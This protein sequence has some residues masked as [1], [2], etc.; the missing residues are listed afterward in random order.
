ME[1]AKYPAYAP[2]AVRNAR[3]ASISVHGANLFNLLPRDIRD[4]DTGTVDMFKARLD[5]WL[6]TVPDQPT[7][8]G[9]QRA[10]ATNSLIDQTVCG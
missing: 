7:T 4:I 9:R 8:P 6:Q 10:A 1:V 3:E 2:A 5:D